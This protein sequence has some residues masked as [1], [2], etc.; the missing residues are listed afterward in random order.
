MKRA[1]SPYGERVF[2]GDRPR[3]SNVPL[4]IGEPAW[5]NP[6]CAIAVAIACLMIAASAGILLAVYSL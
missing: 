3:P 5:V 1:I 2:R 6:F 4:A